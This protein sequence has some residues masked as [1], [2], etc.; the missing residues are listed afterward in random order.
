MQKVSVV[1]VAYNASK[2]LGKCLESLIQQNYLNYEVIVIDDGSTD[3]TL[4]IAKQFSVKFFRCE[5]NRGWGA[6]RNLGLK[7][8]TGKIIA[9]TDADCVVEE[10]WLEK[11]V[12]TFENFPDAGAVGGSVLNPYNSNLSWAEYILNFSFV[13]PQGKIRKARDMPTANIAYRKDRIKGLQFPIYRGKEMII[14][15][16]VLNYLLTKRGY[17]LIFNPD[18]KVYHYHTRDTI[19]KFLEKQ[20]ESGRVHLLAIKMN[21]GFFGKIFVNFRILNFF[22][23]RLFILFKRVLFSREYLCRFLTAFPL[24]LRGEIER[25]KE[26][27][28]QKEVDLSPYLKGTAS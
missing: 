22:L 10:D 6:V 26:I 16:T 13:F 18:I 19:T 14:E 3:D 11:L 23:P 17:S 1:V 20:R 4:R 8:A 25:T 12:N 27:F 28:K 2:T 7:K 15:E 21:G 9:F 5:L 24:I